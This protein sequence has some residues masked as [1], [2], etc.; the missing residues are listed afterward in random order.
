MTDQTTIQ[1]AVCKKAFPLD[2]CYEYRGFIACERDFKELQ[3]KVDHKR[4]EV[5]EITE[6]SVRS[7]A[8]GEW[9]NGGY[10]TMKTDTGGS[11][12][13]SVVKSPQILVDY[14]NGIL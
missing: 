4:R 5:Q 13:P 3:G 14:E 8:S 12:I 11:P 7:Q 2:E 10:K 9:Q 1:C 6:A